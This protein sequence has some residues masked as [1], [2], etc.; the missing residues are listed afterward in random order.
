MGIILDIILIAVVLFFTIRGYKKGLFKSVV[1]LATTF[2]IFPLAILISIPLTTVVYESFPGV[3][4]MEKNLEQYVQSVVSEN[5][6]TGSETKTEDTNII[7]SLINKE[8][9]KAEGQIKDGVVSSVSKSIAKLAVQAL[10]VLGIYVIISIV[11]FIFKGTIGGIIE[12]I[13]LINNLNGVGGSVIELIKVV[14][15]ILVLLYTLRIYSVA[16]LNQK[17]DNFINTTVLTKEI[18]KN[19]ILNT[20]IK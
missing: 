1:E 14:L 19:N 2:I 3:K 15:I 11:L 16:T 9:A 6:Q 8:I 12:N 13:P 20:I 5:N 10:I 18:Y 7:N 17:V 4:T